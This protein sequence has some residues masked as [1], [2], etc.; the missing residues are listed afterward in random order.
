MEDSPQV[1]TWDEKPKPKNLAEL[2]DLVKSLR[3]MG[4]TGPD[5]VWCN[6]PTRRTGACWTCIACGSTSAC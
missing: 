6:A 3:G 1:M 2:S 5:C 4:A